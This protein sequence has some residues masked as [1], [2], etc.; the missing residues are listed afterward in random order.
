MKKAKE[1]NSKINVEKYS[2]VYFHHL[3][4][5][6]EKNASEAYKKQ[7]YVM[8]IYNYTK[9]HFYRI[10]AGCFSIVTGHELMSLREIL[11]KSVI[12]CSG[13]ARSFQAFKKL[14]IE[15]SISE[16]N[17]AFFEFLNSHKDDMLEAEIIVTEHYSRWKNMKSWDRIKLMEELAR[18]YEA[19][20]ISN[21]YERYFIYENSFLHD[22][23]EQYYSGI[24]YDTWWETVAKVIIKNY[25]E[26]NI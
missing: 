13:T 6:C 14:K 4:N 11:E 17:N 26:K 23:F 16:F 9:V 21:I 10:C 2:S 20:N 8:Y 12:P 25:I 15:E 18:Y 5:D 24:I 19:E 7:D 22:K 3:A 1:N